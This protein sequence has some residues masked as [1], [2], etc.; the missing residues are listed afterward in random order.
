MAVVGYDDTIGQQGAF[1]IINSWGDD[2]ANAGFCWVEYADFNRFVA[3]SFSMVDLAVLKEDMAGSFV[4]ETDRG[5]RMTANYQKSSRRYSLKEDYPAK[6]RFRIYLKNDGPSYLYAFGFDQ[7]GKTFK[8]FPHTSQTS[9][10]IPYNKAHV[11]IPDDDHYFEIDDAKGRNELCVI[12]SNKEIDF[13]K[14][15]AD[16]ERS[17]QDT[18]ANERPLREVLEEA[19]EDTET[20]IIPSEMT[21]YSADLFQ[22]TSKR[23][24]QSCAPIIISFGE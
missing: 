6:T 22:F 7:T 14:L 2:W 15:L 20:K 23:D 11:P 24:D 17:S 16:I 12:Y 9:A 1:E 19:L 3:Q 13:D 18:L 5:E 4:M 8:L 21:H 10:F